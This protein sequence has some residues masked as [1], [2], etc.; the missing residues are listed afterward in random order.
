MDER[1]SERED[2]SARISERL[3]AIIAMAEGKSR[4][5]NHLPEQSHRTLPCDLASEQSHQA[6]LQ[7]IKRPG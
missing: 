6:I 7:E 5:T 3:T 4:I 1:V 2:I